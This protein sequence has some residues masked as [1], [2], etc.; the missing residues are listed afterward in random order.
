MNIVQ[1]KEG[2]P[3]WELTADEA[4]YVV[5]IQQDNMNFY[6]LFVFMK[7]PT[8]KEERE[9][10]DQ[11]TILVKSKYVDKNFSHLEGVDVKS[12][13][14]HRSWLNSLP[15]IKPFIYEESVQAA[16]SVVDKDVD[17][18]TELDNVSVKMLHPMY[19]PIKKSSVE[20]SLSFIFNNAEKAYQIFDTAFKKTTL[21]NGELRFGGFDFIDELCRDCLVSV[22]GYSINGVPCTEKNKSEWVNFIPFEHK[23]LAAEEG[24][25]TTEIGIN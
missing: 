13:E 18:L 4:S 7:P 2:K 25:K 21:V 3:F 14:R 19:C 6:D 11:G 24:F 9:V 8:A 12:P 15:N 22:N 20:M 10:R 1:W 17:N 23:L 5:V 16:T